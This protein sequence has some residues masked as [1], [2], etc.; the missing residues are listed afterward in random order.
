M[1]VEVKKIGNSVGIIFPKK[2]TL[3]TFNN[4]YVLTPKIKDIYY[5]DDFWGD[6][7]N[8]MTKEDVEWDEFDT[9]PSEETD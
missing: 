7:R 6:V 4:A 5:N 1:D 3:R 8:E 9:L 2:F